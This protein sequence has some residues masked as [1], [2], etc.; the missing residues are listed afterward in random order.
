MSAP[1]KCVFLSKLQAISPFCPFSFVTQLTFG[2]SE[3]QVLCLLKTLVALPAWAK[4]SV[5]LVP[6]DQVSLLQ[7]PHCIQVTPFLH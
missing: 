4:S 3:L 7:S 5:S 6:P 2:D 1:N